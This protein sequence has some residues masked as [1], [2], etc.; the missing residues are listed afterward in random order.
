M[1]VLDAADHPPANA[2]AARRALWI[3]LLLGMY[4][5]VGGTLS[6]LGWILDRPR[7]SDW[8]MTDL[9]I[10]PNG[11]LAAILTGVALL[12]LTTRYDRLA[13]VPGLAVAVIGGATLFE[14]ATDTSLSID[15]LLLF[16]RTWGL[17]LTVAPGRMGIPASLSFTL[18]GI[19]LMMSRRGRQNRRDTPIIGL[20]VCG[21]AAMGIIGY[22]YGADALFSRPRFTAIAAPTATFLLAAGLG[23]VAAVPDRQPMRML[24]GD[25]TAAVVARRTLPFIV[26]LPVVLGHLQIEGQKAGMYGPS[27]GTALLVLALVMLLCIVWWWGVNA[28]TVHERIVSETNRTLQDNE[29]RV[30]GTLDSITD[31]FV[32]LD[33]SGHFTFVNAE[34]ERMFGRPRDELLGRTLT[35]LFPEYA[36]R[37]MTREFERAARERTM[38][39]FDDV[40]PGTGRSIASRIYPADDGGVSMYFRDTTQQRVADARAFR[41]E[42][43]ART[44]ISVLPGAAVFVVDRELRYTVADGDAL[45]AAGKTPADFVGKTIHEVLDAAKA[46][47]LERRFR[48]AFEGVPFT[49]EHD[50]HDRSFA[51]RGVPLRD[52]SGDVYAV[53]AFSSDITDR[54]ASEVVLR[55]ADRR[56]DEFL[57][58]LAHELRNP[59]A[60]VMN[61]L[62]ILKRAGDDTAL[63]EQASAMMERQLRQMVRL[64][65]DLMDVSRIT[66]NALELRVSRIE[67]TPVLHH[68]LEACGPMIEEAGHH[69]DVVLPEEPVCLDGD[70]ARLAQV[71]GNLLVNACKYTERGGH[72]RV[73]ATV[74]DDQVVVEVHDTGMGIPPDML[75]AVFEPFAQVDRSLERTHG[76]LGIGLS[77]VKQLVTLH[78]GSV[79]AHSDGAGHGST[80][81]VCLPL[82][83]VHAKANVPTGTVPTGTS[84]GPPTIASYPSR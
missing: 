22:L 84:S 15:E 45:H 16:D 5:L 38:V 82:A 67:L 12:L 17:S 58:T 18:I 25:T 33:K 30:V 83:A 41:S 66:R 6:L 74:R 79:S 14:N 2:V 73:T 54:K 43:Q 29:R 59:L 62:A 78:N 37:G 68:A 70:A 40:E 47:E 65:D 72:I 4:T 75:G 46:A 24:I 77:L 64:I 53:M 44:L 61:A 80:F 26:L 20:V 10:Q 1:L 21:V 23:L 50:E 3:A 8:L 76:G 34:A 56:K 60:P 81:T 51:T 69:L 55:E 39:E 49:H 9:A 36:A 27:F 71:F 31:G 32:T 7:W 19:A 52:E 35:E 57:A 11:A 48:L 13:A 42:E 63:A 28:A